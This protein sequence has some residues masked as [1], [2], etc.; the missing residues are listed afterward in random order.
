[1]GGLSMQAG[2][3]QFIESGNPRS[4]ARWKKALEE[5]VGFDYVRDRGYKGEIFEV[6]ADGYD[7]AD[8]LFLES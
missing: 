2:S 1:M 4:E 6:T 8:A 3:K 5:L 7:V